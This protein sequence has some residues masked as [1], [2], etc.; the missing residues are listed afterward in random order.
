MKTMDDLRKE[1]DRAL[2]QV[3]YLKQENDYLKY[4]LKEAEKS[5]MEAAASDVNVVT[6]R[7]FDGYLEKFE[8]SEVR[9]GVTL[10]FMRLVDGS[11]RHIPLH[12]VRWYSLS[13]E[14]HENNI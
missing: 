4:M 9:F 12:Q 10:L 11:N 8:C 6:V 3:S 13:K 5:S 1:R 7:W 14:S 2:S